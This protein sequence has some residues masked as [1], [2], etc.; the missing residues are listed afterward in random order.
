MQHIETEVCIAGAGPAGVIASLFLAREGIPSVLVDKDHFPRDK[1]C[2]D[3]V[4]G[5]VLSVLDRLDPAITEEL[6]RQDFATHSYGV[7]FFA[8]NL[9]N[10]LVSFPTNG[11]DHPPGVIAR[12]VELDQYLIGLVRKNRL[13]TLVEGTN[14]S[15]AQRVNGQIIVSDKEGSIQVK[16][17]MLLLATGTDHSLFGPLGIETNKSASL[18]LGI[19]C[20]YSNVKGS[21]DHH[22]IEI[23]FL[24]ELLPW[25]FWIFPF[26][27]HTANVGLALPMEIVKKRRLKLADLLQRVMNDYPHLKTRFEGAKMTGKPEACILPFHY[28]KKRI[29]G[30]NYLQLGDTASLID[31]FTGEGMGNAMISGEIAAETTAKF[32]RTGQFGYNATIEY[33]LK[34]YK[35]LEQELNL[36]LRLQKLAK[37]AFLVNLVVN[38]ASS[39]DKVR[40]HLTEMIYSINSKGKLSTKMFY[41]KL[42]LGI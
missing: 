3:G 7:R 35:A 36:G 17:R 34:L 32:I 29:A 31:P 16:A 14:L 30:D 2:G 5:K 25:Y 42:M 23:H 41:Y 26:K 4:S 38:K 6:C 27:D 37:K 40:E 19:R 39:R 33:Q 9:N 28:G 18:G 10:V 11:P 8:P 24:K 22:A 15:M 21:E 20:Y 1:I 13:I 12:R